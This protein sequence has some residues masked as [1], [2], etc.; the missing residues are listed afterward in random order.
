M[1]FVVASSH[2]SHCERESEQETTSRSRA[3]RS[4]RLRGCTDTTTVIMESQP[5]AR[6]TASPPAAV[7]PDATL[8]AVCQLLNNAP[9]ARASPS[10]A[11][12]WRDDVDQLIIAAINMPHWE[13]RCQPSAQQSR[14]PSAA[15][16]P[17][18]AQAPPG[19]PGARPLAQHRASMASYRTTDL[20]E[21]INRRRDEEDSRTTIER[22]HERR[23]DIEG[24][25]LERDFDLH[26][27]VG[28][29][30]VAHA[31]LPLAPREF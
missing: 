23:R 21:E 2:P 9:S 27:P 12:Q 5:T 22:N 16:T 15:C 6:T 10:V 7:G 4:R 31:P 25:N 20:R 28:A 1:V 18:V 30:Q 14:F 26:A 11:E 24:R 17:S 29:R 19:V 3:G 13:G 8:L